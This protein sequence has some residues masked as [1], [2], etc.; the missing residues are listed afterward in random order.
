M[1]PIDFGPDDLVWLHTLNRLRGEGDSA[2]RAALEQRI[3]HRF[4][5]DTRLAVYGT[6]APG[7]PNERQ[8]SALAGQWHSGGAV[9]GRFAEHGWG[10]ALGYPALAWSEDGP[11]VPVQVFVS[12]ELPRHWS[13]LDAFEGEEY[14]RI[15][16]PVHGAGGVLVVANLYAVG[17]Q[18]WSEYQSL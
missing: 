10:A 15:L 2:E 3:E 12:P 5:A 8:L 18:G 1:N 7:E 17:T 6:L 16:V 11:P 9:R 14:R 4:G 13:R